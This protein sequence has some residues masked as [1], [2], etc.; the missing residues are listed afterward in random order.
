[1]SITRQFLQFGCVGI[2]ATIID[3]GIFNLLTRAA[4]GWRRIP[5]NIVSVAVGKDFNFFANWQLFF[6]PAG[7]DC[8]AM[9]GKCLTHALS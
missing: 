4:V 3:V 2:G 9:T 8:L 7:Q 1:M 6:R 5:A